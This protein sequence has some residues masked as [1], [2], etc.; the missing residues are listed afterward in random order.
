MDQ[1]QITVTEAVLAAYF[2][3]KATPEES[4]AVEKWRLLSPGNESAFR[5]YALIWERSGNFV[6]VMN[7]N[8]CSIFQLYPEWPLGIVSYFKETFSFKP[9]FTNSGTIVFCVIKK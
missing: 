1:N 2:S 3:G 4:A 5:D 6:P 9:D 7:I 8:I